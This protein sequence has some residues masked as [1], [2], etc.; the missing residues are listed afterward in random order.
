MNQK[1][2]DYLQDQVKFTGFGDE[3][4]ALLK[5]ALEKGA[6]EF[7]L[8]HNTRFSNDDVAAVLHFKKSGQT[9]MYFFNRYDV[10]LKP[11][12]SKE[13]LTQSFYI[14]KGSN[15]TLKEAYN[16]M[17][18]RAVNK[19]LTTKEGELYNAWVQMDFKQADAHG[20]YK[21]Q[22]YHQNY[23]YDLEA[24]LARHPIKELSNEQDK[25]RLIASLQKGNIQSVT[26]LG[27][28]GSE[29][30]HFVEASPQFK[31]INVYDSNLQ[32]LDI[33]QAKGERQ[34]EGENKG[35]RQRQGRSERQQSAADD[36]AKM[37]AAQKAGKKK[38]G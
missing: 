5:A 10:T 23:G 17:N 7:A 37:P 22:H 8:N 1:N 9:G 25:D 34:N 12:G 35:A 31:T 11:E 29:Q 4:G 28:G 19:D 33:K 32:R 15:I 27:E 13:D 2:L 36:S 16:L 21:L 18:G 3:L 26:F 6:P 14:N 24:A 30:K 38:Q 20:N